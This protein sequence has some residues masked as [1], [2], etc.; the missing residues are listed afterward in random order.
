M[1]SDSEIMPPVSYSKGLSA[2]DPGAGSHECRRADGLTCTCWSLD[3]AA[4][5]LANLGHAQ[6]TRVVHAVL[7]VC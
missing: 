3:L 5:C 7:V 2:A 4:Q 1:T 6:L